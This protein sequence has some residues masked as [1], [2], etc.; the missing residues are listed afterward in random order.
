LIT[1]EVAGT[2]RLNEAVAESIALNLHTTTQVS[3][4]GGVSFHQYLAFV[5]VVEKYV[6]RAVSQYGCLA[7][8]IPTRLPVVF[9]YR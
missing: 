7:T 5:L 1:I 8:R 6:Q 4:F 2:D 3:S 9:R